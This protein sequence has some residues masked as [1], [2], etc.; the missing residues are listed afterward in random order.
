[1]FFLK[2]ELKAQ[3]VN[4]LDNDFFA[5]LLRYEVEQLNSNRKK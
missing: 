5:A 3:E 1:M 4:F 2:P